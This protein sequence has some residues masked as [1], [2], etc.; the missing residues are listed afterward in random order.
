MKG[1]NEGG[2]K[3]VRTLNDTMDDKKEKPQSKKQKAETIEDEEKEKEF[4]NLEHH[5]DGTIVGCFEEKDHLYL[6]KLSYCI[7]ESK[8]SK[9][10][11][12]L[13]MH[14]MIQTMKLH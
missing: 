6:T 11:K 13:C 3:N 1:K 7:C 5:D 8:C 4:R 12:V 9:C 14:L 2:K 10:K